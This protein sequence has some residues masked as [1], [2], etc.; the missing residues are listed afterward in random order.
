MRNNGDRGALFSS[1]SVGSFSAA[2]LVSTTNGACVVSC[3]RLPLPLSSLAFVAHALQ[4][5]PGAKEAAFTSR[6]AQGATATLP[7]CAMLVC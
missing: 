5:R 3:L 6:C 1:S 4:Q 7:P 2:T